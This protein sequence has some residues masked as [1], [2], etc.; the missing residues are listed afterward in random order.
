V[1]LPQ[2]GRKAKFP[3][4]NSFDFFTIGGCPNGVIRLGKKQV[5]C[6][7]FATPLETKEFSA[8]AFTPNHPINIGDLE[9]IEPEDI[10][11]AELIRQIPPLL[12]NARLKAPHYVCSDGKRKFYVARPDPKKFPR[13]LLP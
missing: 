3:P 6:R 8:N 11:S 7:I 1:N 13:I 5:A 9:S 12:A 10:E 2:I 4:L